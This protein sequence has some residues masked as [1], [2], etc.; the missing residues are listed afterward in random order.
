MKSRTGLVLLLALWAVTECQCGWGA[1]R[2]LR[3]AAAK[4]DVDL[5]KKLLD[6]G[7]DV[8]SADVFHQTALHLAALHGQKAV[9]ELLIERGADVNA[10][11]DSGATPL[12]YA[13]SNGQREVAALLGR[14]GAISGKEA[15]AAK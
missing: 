3:A 2:K 6:E 4:G 15:R 5:V 12:N 9:A 11:D 13:R 1:N 8:N 10:R 7:A 14:H